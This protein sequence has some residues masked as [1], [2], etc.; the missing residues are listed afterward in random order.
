M[1]SQSIYAFSNH[2]I[3]FGKVSSVLGEKK[4]QCTI[5]N[6]LLN[7][8]ITFEGLIDLTQLDSVKKRDLWA[9][10][11]YL[12][13]QNRYIDVFSKHPTPTELEKFGS[14]NYKTLYTTKLHLAGK[15]NQVINVNRD[16]I[17][18]SVISTLLTTIQQ[19]I[20]KEEAELEKAIKSIEEF[21]HN[22]PHYNITDKFGNQIPGIDAEVS[23]KEIPIR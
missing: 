3:L 21:K 11:Y 22:N 7:A 2:P 9:Y 13:T 14:I 19:K 20:N 12:W 18:I 15:I 10:L 16:K 4:I 5:V 6:M 1:D 8:I 23:L 17:N